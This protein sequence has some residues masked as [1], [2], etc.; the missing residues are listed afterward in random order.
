MVII[1]IY[2]MS[3]SFESLQN[4]F[5]GSLQLPEDALRLVIH[6]FQSFPYITADFS[7]LS[8]LIDRP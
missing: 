7:H 6:F 8:I 5:D 1:D 4:G 2:Q 3:A